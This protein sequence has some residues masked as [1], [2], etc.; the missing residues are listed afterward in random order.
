MSVAS[1][2]AAL[3]VEAIE[4]GWCSGRARRRRAR[5][6]R[7]AVSAPTRLAATIESERAS[8]DGGRGQKRWR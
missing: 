7:A 1:F 2:W 4:E 8:E 5:R 3:Q 6:R